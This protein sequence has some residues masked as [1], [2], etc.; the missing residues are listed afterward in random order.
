[1]RKKVDLHYLY[2]YRLEAV[3]QPIFGVAG[4]FANAFAIPVLCR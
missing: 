1:M 3:M 4:F 2:L